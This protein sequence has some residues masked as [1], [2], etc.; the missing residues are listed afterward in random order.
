ME[1]SLQHNRMA[2]NSIQEGAGEISIARGKNWGF[3]QMQTPPPLR[4]WRS[5]R[6]KSMLLIDNRPSFISSPS[7]DSV[8][9]TISALN[10]HTH[11]RSSSIFENMERALVKNTDGQLGVVSKEVGR[12]FNRSEFSDKIFSGNFDRK[13]S[14]PLFHAVSSHSLLGFVC[15][16]ILPSVVCFGLAEEV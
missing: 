16:A 6:N 9:T 12:V 8:T 11:K 14:V 7:Q 2:T 13:F 15:D 1:N 4:N 5:Q 10:E 3:A